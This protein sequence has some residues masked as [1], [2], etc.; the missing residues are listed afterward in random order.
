VRCRRTA[1]AYFTSTVVIEDNEM[2][3]RLIVLVVLIA[4]CSFNPD[5]TSTEEGSAGAGAD[6]AAP[7]AVG[8]SLDAGSM[9]QDAGDAGRFD[10]L[11]DGGF[12]AVTPTCEKMYGTANGFDLCEATV[13]SCRFYVI[14]SEDTC[15]NL[16]TSFGGACIDNYDGNCASNIG[17]QGCD[18][19]H[20]DQVCICTLPAVSPVPDQI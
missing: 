2:V 3:S 8:A 5:T 14:T 1:E 15:T 6:A 16:C 20:Q 11:G 4:G 13:N 12:T 10:Q 19:V 18:V 17:S 7:P 9:E